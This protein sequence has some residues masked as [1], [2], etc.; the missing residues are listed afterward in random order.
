MARLLVHAEAV[1]AGTLF[2]S[3]L[4][5]LRARYGGGAWRTPSSPL[6]LQVAD[7]QGS[8]LAE[9]RDAGPLTVFDLPAGTVVVTAVCGRARRSYTLTLPAGGA[10]ELH[11]H[12]GPDGP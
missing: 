9:V 8:H 3:A 4:H 11:L 10:F 2:E 12:F 1:A 5:H 7:L 6:A